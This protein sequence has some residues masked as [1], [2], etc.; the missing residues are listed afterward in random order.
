MVAGKTA[1]I[2]VGAQKCGTSWLFSYLAGCPEI[3]ASRIKELHYFESWLEPQRFPDFDPW[4]VRTLQAYL[5]REGV[6]AM[7]RPLVRDL[8]DRVRAIGYPQGYLMHFQRLGGGERP[9]FLDITPSYSLLSVDSYRTM[10][11]FLQNAGIDVKIVFLM[12]DPVERYFSALRMEQRDRANRDQSF[13]ASAAFDEHL[14]TP[15][16]HERTRYDRTIARLRQV[17]PAEKIFIGFYETL[18]HERTIGALTD[19]LGIAYRQPDFGHRRNVSPE[20][21]PLSREQ[22]ERGVAAFAPVYADIRQRFGDAV[23]DSWR[24]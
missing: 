14:H 24:G 12:R 18:F 5:A 20:T 8:L 13:S 1:V 22:I 19:F 17:Y 23:P 15:S 4:F 16:F 2:G 11:D 3:T 9:L 7:R 21:E 10:R 6:Q